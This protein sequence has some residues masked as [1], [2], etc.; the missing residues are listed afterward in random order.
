M[1]ISNS[2]DLFVAQYEEYRPHL[3]QH[4]VDRKV[5]H[6]DTVI[7]QLTSQALHQMTFL[8]PESMKLI[9][10][11]QILPRCSNPE[12]YLRH[13]S[14]LASGKVISALCQVA[15]DHQRRLPDELGQLPLVISY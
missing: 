3:I 8:D 5:I 13:G 6:W 7:R 11:T 4:L 12:L 14:I 1:P 9:L 2:G 15:K 10:S